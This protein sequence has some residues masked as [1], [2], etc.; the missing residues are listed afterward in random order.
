MQHLWHI[1]ISPSASFL[2]KKC[3]KIIGDWGFAPDPTGGAYNHR[4]RVG[5]GTFFKHQVPGYTM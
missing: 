1:L 5:A 3:T 4:L 2:S